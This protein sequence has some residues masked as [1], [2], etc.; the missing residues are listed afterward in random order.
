MSNTLDILDCKGTRVG[1]YVIPEGVMI[2]LNNEPEKGLQAVHDTV[3]AYLAGLRAGTACTKTRGEVSGGGAKPF[4]QKGT[5]RARSG[6]SR[7]PV[8]VG[9]GTIFGPRPRSFAKKVNKKVLRLALRRAFT[10]RIADGDVVVVDQVQLPDH[11]TKNVVSILKNLN[12][13]DST[14][15][16]SLPALEDQAAVVCATGNL[17]NLVLRKSDNVNVY[18]L[19]RFGKLLFT[20]DG[21]DAFIQRLA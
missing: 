18:E 12:L 14:V 7:S 4:R 10:E 5:G 21:L 16:M 1:E 15:M 13:A 2:E 17:P 20:K 9:G 11:K 19:L 6:S 3:V 8:W